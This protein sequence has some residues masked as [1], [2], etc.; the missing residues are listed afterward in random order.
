[1]FKD[2]I[3]DES[4]ESM[5]AQAVVCI[6]P[7][8]YEKG[9]DYF[10]RKRI[11]WTKSFGPRIYSAVNDG[12][13]H[14]VI[15]HLD[16]FKKSTCTCEKKQLCEHIAAVF[17]HYCEP[18]LKANGILFNEVSHIPVMNPEPCVPVME[19]PVELWYEYFEFEYARVREAKKRSFQSSDYFMG[20]FSF[21]VRLF[22]DFT[23][24]I[25]AHNNNWPAF[26]KALLRFHSN[27]FFMARLE[28]Q[29][30][31]NKSSYIDNYQIGQ[32]ED[33]FLKDYSLLLSGKQQEIYQPFFRKAVEVVHEHL[34]QEETLLY[35]WLFIYRIMCVNYFGGLDCWKN[36]TIILEEYMKESGKNQ[37]ACYYAALGLASVNLAAHRN[38]AALAVLKELKIKRIEDML[39]YL[40]YLIKAKQWDQLL[41]WLRWLTPEIRTAMPVVFEDIC[42]CCLQASEKSSAKEEFINLVRS[43]LPRSFNAYARYLLEAGLFREWAE[44]TMSYRGYTWESIDKSVLRHLES[45]DPAALIPLYHQWAAR[46][47]EEKNR[48][49]YQGAVRLLKKLRTIYNRQKMAK[50]WNTFI[51]RLAARYPRMRALHEELRKGK[52]IS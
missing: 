41:V 52:L 1:M 6:D 48:K 7:E 11:T 47:I 44:L 42:G 31:G 51:F 16:D 9:R 21:S 26:N 37:Q 15:I 5:A 32:I 30:K 3:T 19:G 13:T 24:G 12:K 14:T 46:L 49:A 38:D 23:S 18:W 50:E 22:D 28:K 27:L 34:F 8:L 36:E 40:L 35:D 25:S 10:Q 33:G 4:I 39:F 17:F 2:K 29:V 43:W 45:R 20:E